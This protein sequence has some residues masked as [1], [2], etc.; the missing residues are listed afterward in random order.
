MSP[1]LRDQD[2]E[3]CRPGRVIDN[4]IQESQ[5]SFLSQTRALQTWLWR[6]CKGPRSSQEFSCPN[7]Q[8]DYIDWGRQWFWHQLRVQ[9]AFFCRF[10]CSWLMDNGQC[11]NINRESLFIKLW[12]LNN[13]IANS[14]SEIGTELPPSVGAVLRITGRAQSIPL[15]VPELTAAAKRG[16]FFY[17]E[18]WNQ[19]CPVDRGLC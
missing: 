15:F 11:R 19:G 14:H 18:G 9:H 4:E 1:T 17:L 12:A 3:S 13:L 16:H 10:Q 7:L 5:M 2:E 8:G 6:I